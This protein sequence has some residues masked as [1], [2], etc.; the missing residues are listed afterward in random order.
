MRDIVYKLFASLIILLALTVSAL[1]QTV[2]PKA[3]ET[4]N[5]E[6]QKDIAGNWL[7]TLNAGGVGL[8]LGLKVTR[9]ADGT[10]SA[11][12]DSIDQ[13]GFDLPVDLI[14]QDASVVK[15][16]MKQP[17]I[18]YEGTLNA[19][20]D[21]I[22]GNF[23]QGGGTLPLVFKRNTQTE[24]VAA[25]ARKQDP[26]KPYPYQ[27]E[28]VTYENKPD[29]VKLAG[30]LTIPRAAAGETAAKTFPAVI[31][32][33]GSGA[34]DRNST[35]LGHRPFLVIADYLT[36]RGIAVLRVD[37]RG[38]GG[39]STGAKPGT[40]ADYARDVLAG[41]E[42]L[43]NRL[44]VDPRRIGLI[45]HSEGGMIAPLVASQSKDVAFIV[46]LAGSGQTGEGLLYSQ[47]ALLYKANGAPAEYAK[48][49]IDWV[50]KVYAVIKVQPDNKLAAEQIRAVLAAEAADIEKSSA[51]SEQQK[52]FAAW[53]AEMEKQIPVV[54]S[55]WFRYFVAYDPRP[56]LEKV[57]I[58]VLALNGE[59]D[60]QVAPQENLTLIEA[61]L[62]AGGNKNYTIK[63]LPQLNHLFQTSQTGLPG[64]YSTIEETIAPQ[65]L[66]M[67]GD[68]ILKQ[69]K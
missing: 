56:I 52:H 8:R 16:E 50:R 46:M 47:T 11:K 63:S 33:T 30:T 69:K 45:G 15:F 59:N 24:N 66:E 42:Y 17:G 41:I 2:T 38:V 58:P 48:Q 55:R 34:Q 49:E 60:L 9:A 68:W 36:R 26:V 23:K 39:S 35:I 7:G 43:K 14:T 54:T 61:A 62:K 25:E 57:Q 20:A 3:A 67:I 18:S 6:K 28:E 13:G 44:E 27:E 51:A 31:L 10:L 29:A 40:S 21:E 12:F 22:S 37:D 65:V 19:Q 5:T 32:I 1:P 53:R 64:E 4:N